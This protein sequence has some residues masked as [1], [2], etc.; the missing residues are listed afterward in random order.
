MTRLEPTSD[1][2][3]SFA[4]NGLRLTECSWVTR[5]S[6]CRTSYQSASWAPSSANL[7]ALYAAIVG[8]AIMPPT[9]LMVTIRAAR[10]ARMLGSTRR[11]ISIGDRKLTFI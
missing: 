7:D 11:I 3:I 9:E 1:R 4:M 2:R 6:Y 5:I 10:F 8:I